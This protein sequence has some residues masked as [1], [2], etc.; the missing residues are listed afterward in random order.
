MRMPNKHKA[1]TE[2]MTD[3]HRAALAD[4]EARR[5]EDGHEE[6]VDAFNAMITAD[7]GAENVGL[8]LRSYN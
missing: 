1:Q 2:L 7:L 6:R 4:L 5:H 3:A 8:I